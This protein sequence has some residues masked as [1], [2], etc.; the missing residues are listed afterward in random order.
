MKLSDARRARL[1]QLQW[2]VLSVKAGHETAAGLLLQRLG[3]TAFVPTVWQRRRRLAKHHRKIMEVTR[4]LAARYVLIGFEDDPEWPRVLSY[5][6]IL[7]AVGVNGRPS[8][9]PDAVLTKLFAA[10]RCESLVPVDVKERPAERKSVLVGK[11]AQVLRGW[12]VGQRVTI[13]NVKGQR[14]EVL[15]RETDNPRPVNVSFDNLEMID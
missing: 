6:W 3:F 10:H 13:E 12:L 7:S 11:V 5:P 15:P 14:A 2:Y 8:R 4:P 9:L 1:L